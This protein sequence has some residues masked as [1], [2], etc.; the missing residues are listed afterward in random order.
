MQVLNQSVPVE[1]HQAFSELVRNST[2]A[3][4]GGT[5]ALSTDWATMA[6]CAAFTAVGAAAAKPVGRGSTPS[7]LFAQVLASIDA[8]PMPSAVPQNMKHPGPDC[9]W[10]LSF[11]DSFK[12]E[13]QQCL[14]VAIVEGRTLR[15]AIETAEALGIHPGGRV[16]SVACTAFV[17]AAVWRN[18]LLSREE[19]VAAGDSMEATVA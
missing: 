15:E 2:L 4:K 11:S 12:P 1:F 9:W 13:G 3:A 5:I 18:R 17:P 7:G 10:W 6:L 8:R 16:A 19:V 14:G